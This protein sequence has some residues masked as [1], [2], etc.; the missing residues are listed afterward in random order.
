M[1][2]REVG[3][4]EGYELIRHLL[5]EHYEEVAKFKDLH[6]LQPDLDAYLEAERHGA[7][8]VLV[9]FVAERVAGYSVGSLKF[10]PHYAATRFY[11]NDIVYVAPVF[12][13]GRMF[14]R[15][16]Q[17]TKRIARERGA[18]L[19]TWHTKPGTTMHEIMPRVGC[20]IM[21]VVWAER[22]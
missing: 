16:R 11:A 12:R 1:M 20:E 13:R 8:V 14:H 7:L 3:A 2:I 6:V 10:N 9:A 22:L 18:V 21:D 17:E 5:P 19:C 15:L 4:L